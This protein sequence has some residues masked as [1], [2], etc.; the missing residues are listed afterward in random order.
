MTDLNLAPWDVASL[1]DFL[2]YCC[3]ECDL[4]VKD[5]DFFYA[6]AVQNHSKAQIALT[7]NDTKYDTDTFDTTFDTNVIKQEVEDMDYDDPDFDI[8]EV[9][10]Q[11]ISFHFLP[12]DGF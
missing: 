12:L 1:E 10:L 6:H 4:K 5:P 8:G 9:T 7:Q 11:Y 2:Y 3:P